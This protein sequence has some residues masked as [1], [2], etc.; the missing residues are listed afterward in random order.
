[1]DTGGLPDLNLSS[2]QLLDICASLTVSITNTMFLHKAIQQDYLIVM[3]KA[4]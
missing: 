4:K 3:N 1:M 2:V